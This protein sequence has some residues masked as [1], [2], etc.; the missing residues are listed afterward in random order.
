MKQEHFDIA[1]ELQQRIY[2][3]KYFSKYLQG[4]LGGKGLSLSAK[5]EIFGAETSQPLEW[6]IGSNP[7]GV[8]SNDEDD[9]KWFFAKIEER[10][11]ELQKQFDEL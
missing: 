8:L 3:L 4:R 6:A 11:A 9:A 5:I 7:Q 2:S 10:I 1:K